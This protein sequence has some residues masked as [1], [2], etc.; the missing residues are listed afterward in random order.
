MSGA[1]WRRGV[2]PV[3]CGALVGA[4]PVYAPEERFEGGEYPP[5]RLETC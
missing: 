3:V 5:S 4:K 1:G 2:V